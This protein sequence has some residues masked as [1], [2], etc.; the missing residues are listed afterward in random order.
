MLTRKYYGLALILLLPLAVHAQNDNRDR[1]NGIWIGKGGGAP[2]RLSELPFSE[3]GKAIAKAYNHAEDGILKCLFDF[4]RVTSVRFPMEVIVTDSQVTLLYEYGHQVRRVFLDQPEFSTA[5]PPNLMGYSI[6]HWED[7]TLVVETR[8]L[9][10]GWA[11]MEG[12][13]P[14]SEDTVVIERFSLNDAGDVMTIERNFDDLENYTEPWG[15]THQYE[16]SEWKIF[17]YDCTVGSFGSDL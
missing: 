10:A 3:K 1:F 6:G 12:G 16:P 17:P 15:Y 8:K 11:T 13:G 14:Y 9:T 2:P 5:Y 4:G 7:D